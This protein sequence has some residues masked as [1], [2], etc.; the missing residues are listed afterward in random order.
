MYAAALAAAIGAVLSFVGLINAVKVQWNAS[1]GVTLGYLFLAAILAAFGWQNRRDGEA[2][3]ELDDELLFVNGTLMRGLELHP[4]LDGAELL[5]ETSTA[6]V[7]RVHSIDDVHPGMYRV[8]DG[9]QGASI[10]GELYHV[11]V[12][13]L[14]RVIEGEPEGLY[15]GPVELTDGRVVPGILYR[16]ERAVQH[17]DITQHGGW[18]GYLVVR[19]AVTVTGG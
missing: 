14:L 10:A 1:P 8:A 2:T 12:D 6:P 7:Y 17:P 3:N 18:R 4:T 15:R 5:E 13:V 16:R 11:P 19:E 9:E